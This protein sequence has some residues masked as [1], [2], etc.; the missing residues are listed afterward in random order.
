M[1]IMLFAESGIG[2]P[3]P[4]TS[5]IV[6]AA[7]EAIRPYV[8]VEELIIDPTDLTVVVKYRGGTTA[9]LAISPS[10]TETVV[11]V[12]GFDFDTQTKPALTFRSMWVR[13]GNSD[14]DTLESSTGEVPVLGAWTTRN[15]PWWKL[16]RNV[17]SIHNTWAPDIRL[18]G[19]S[20]YRTWAGGFPG[21]TDHDPGLDFDCGGLTT[22]V[23]W[24]VGGDPT[25]AVDDADLADLAPI[26]DHT[27]DPDSLLYSYRRTDAA[28]ED[29]N[30]TITAEYSPEPQELGL[31]N[32]SGDWP[33]A[34]RNHRGG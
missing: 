10:R 23:E 32:A 19:I 31:G 7:A 3:P 15:G 11:D 18:E 33:W 4:G 28:N 25:D 24:V 14:G 16:K 29:S 27:S 6:G 20:P 1:R 9:N 34:D 5:V 13:D 26:F 17:P 2:G 21:L 22:G 30:T 12:T 8:D